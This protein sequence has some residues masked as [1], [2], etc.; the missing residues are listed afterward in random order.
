MHLIRRLLELSVPLVFLQGES[1]ERAFLGQPGRI[2]K[3]LA[4][5]KLSAQLE[6]LGSRLEIQSIKNIA[7]VFSGV[8]TAKKVGKF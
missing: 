6:T 7:A 3:E 1:P 8:R 4:E 2:S 5:G